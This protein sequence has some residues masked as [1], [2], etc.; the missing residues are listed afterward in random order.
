MSDFTAATM[1]HILL[2][3]LL[4]VRRYPPTFIETGTMNG[5]TTALALEFPCYSRVVTI[6]KSPE[7]ATKARQRFAAEI[8][9]GRLEL[10]Q[11]NSGMILAGLCEQV[12][13]MV[14]KF[15]HPIMFYLDAHWCR[16]TNIAGRDFFPLWQELAAIAKRPQPDIVVVDDVRTFGYEAAAPFWGH[17]SCR[18]IADTLGRVHKDLLLDDQYAVYREAAVS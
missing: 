1:N 6:E 3:G 2:R 10:L 17:V 5:D 15:D 9:D 14:D 18:R 7:L 12:P 4:S 8:A 16:G 11:G 13:D